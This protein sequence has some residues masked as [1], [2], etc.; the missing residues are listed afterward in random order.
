VRR[1]PVGR[2]SVVRE[3]WSCLLA[4]SELLL[5]KLPGWGPLA[6]PPTLPSS[7]HGRRVGLNG[8]GCY[9]CPVGT[10]WTKQNCRHELCVAENAVSAAL[11]KLVGRVLVAES[12]D[13]VRASVG[14][15][16]KAALRSAQ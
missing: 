1:S 9:A 13:E 8:R 16:K 14:Q 3:G 7:D 12:C 15:G 10:R 5:G 2:G 6:L 4:G 11:T